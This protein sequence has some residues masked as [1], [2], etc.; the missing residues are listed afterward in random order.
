MR[1]RTPDFDTKVWHTRPAD[2]RLVVVSGVGL[3]QEWAR[4]GNPSR[5]CGLVPARGQAQ[6][7]RRAS[8]DPPGNHRR[9]GRRECG[10]DGESER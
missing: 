1:S 10:M 4:A 7:W 2:Q 6:T 8:D 5:R 9:R 3:T